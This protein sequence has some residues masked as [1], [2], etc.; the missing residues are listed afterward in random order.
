[1][2]SGYVAANGRLPET[3]KGCFVEAKP[4]KRYLG[5]RPLW[6]KVYGGLGSGSD[7]GF[8]EAIKNLNVSYRDWLFEISQFTVSAI[9]GR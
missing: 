4:K 6:R 8:F 3:T 5:M 1:M 9:T 2:D 7:F